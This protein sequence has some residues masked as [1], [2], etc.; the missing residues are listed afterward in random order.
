MTQEIVDII[1]GG[2]PVGLITA[3]YAGLRQASVKNCWNSATTRWAT[4]NAL[5]RKNGL[6]YSSLP[7]NYSRWFSRKFE[8]QLERFPETQYCLEEAIELTKTDFGYKVVASKQTHLAK[9]V[10]ITCGNEAFRQRKLN[11]ENAVNYE[12]R[13]LHYFV[14]NLEQFRNRSVVI[15]GWLGTCLRTNR[16]E[17]NNYSP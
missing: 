5:S 4:R 12:N 2:G 13:N 7:W 16:K 10:I 14:T 17:S 3:F 6:W 8:K 11:V 9:T 15:C 1:I